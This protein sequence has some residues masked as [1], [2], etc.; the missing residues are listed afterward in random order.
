MRAAHRTVNVR[1]P[2]LNN[3]RHDLRDDIALYT[4]N[5]YE[6]RKR[7]MQLHIVKIEKKSNE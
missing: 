6:N 1:H 7:T 3:T 2:A 4:A 5:L